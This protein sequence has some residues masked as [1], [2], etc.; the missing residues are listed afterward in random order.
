MGFESVAPIFR[1]GR[2]TR[3]NSK[4]ET[5][6]LST[7]SH[8]LSKVESHLHTMLSHPIDPIDL[9][10]GEKKTVYYCSILEKIGMNSNLRNAD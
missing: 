5:S 4:E 9:L 3:E 6:N 10:C 2:R 1:G 8:R 7:S